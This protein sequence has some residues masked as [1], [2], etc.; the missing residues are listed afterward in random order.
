MARSSNYEGFLKRQFDGNFNAQVSS[1]VSSSSTVSAYLLSMLEQQLKQLLRPELVGCPDTRRSLQVVISHRQLNE[2]DHLIYDLDVS[3]AQD[4]VSTCS[5][6]IAS[7][8]EPC[9]VLVASMDVWLQG[10][11]PNLEKSEDILLKSRIIWIYQSPWNWRGKLTLLVCKMF[12]IRY[13][14]HLLK[15]LLPKVP[16]PLLHLGGSQPREIRRSSFN[17]AG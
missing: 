8:T 2:L 17:S 4:A 1:D 16:F 6:N 9:H 5:V 12:E 11:E 7:G 3:R 10:E 14:S 15:P 13:V